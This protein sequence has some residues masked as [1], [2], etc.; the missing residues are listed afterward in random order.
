MPDFLYFCFPTTL[1]CIPAMVEICTY[2]NTEVINNLIN[3]SK[4]YSLNPLAAIA[5]NM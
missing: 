2:I 3:M 4:W 1:T 5:T